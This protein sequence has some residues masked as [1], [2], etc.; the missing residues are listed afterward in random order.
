MIAHHLPL[1]ESSDEEPADTEGG[2]SHMLYILFWH[3]QKAFKYIYSRWVLKIVSFPPIIYEETI[4]TVSIN[5]WASLVALAVKNPSANA[6]DIRDAGSIA[7][8][9]RSPGGGHGNP[10]QYS[11]LENPMDRRASKDT[12]HGVTKSWTTEVT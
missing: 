7:G 1:V 10:L 5:L 4:Y 6:G 11:C 3:V 12:V 8:L 9:G 2:A